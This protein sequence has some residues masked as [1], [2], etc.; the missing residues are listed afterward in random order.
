[1]AGNPWR[2]RTAF[3]VFRYVPKVEDAVDVVKL[4]FQQLSDRGEEWQIEILGPSLPSGKILLTGVLEAV[5]RADLVIIV[6]GEVSHNVAF[7]LGLAYALDKD[8]I[9]LAPK[10]I[11]ED[12]PR[13]FSDISGVKCAVYDADRIMKLPEVLEGEMQ[14]LN[15][16]RATR[17]TRALSPDYL[18]ALGDL[19]QLEGLY[20]E[21]IAKYQAACDL[22]ARNIRYLVRLGQAYAAAYD[23][24]RAEEVLRRAATLDAKCTMALDAL[25][26]VLLDAGK[27]QA[28]IDDCLMTA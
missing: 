9:L 13:T 19:L 18:I 3:V 24:N 23:L 5:R 8:M 7:E 15:A 1:M 27:Y 26:Q 16:N 21:A 11:V 2:S 17:V 6:A 22:D 25:S 4:Y 10:Q 12:I 20:D 14:A 28:A